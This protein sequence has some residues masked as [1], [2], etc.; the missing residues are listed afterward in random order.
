MDFT[1]PEIT[2]G[3]VTSD[4]SIINVNISEFIQLDH[5]GSFNTDSFIDP[6][7]SALDQHVP[8]IEPGIDPADSALDQH[9][10][11]IEPGI[12]PADSALDQ[13]VPPI[14]PND[15]GALSAPA[16]NWGTNEVKNAFEVNINGRLLEANEFS[17]DFDSSRNNIV[18][19]L[20]APRVVYEGQSV[21]LDFDNNKLSAYSAAQITDIN[22]NLLQSGFIAI[23]NDSFQTQ[24]DWIL[25]NW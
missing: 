8:P 14:E 3:F 2:D 12:D 7:D 6:A 9:V 24:T 5:Q 23:Q 13:H 4:G 21:N 22:G 25:R 17:L 10:P 16:Y 11:P 18:I 19:N 1:E 20:Q 15:D